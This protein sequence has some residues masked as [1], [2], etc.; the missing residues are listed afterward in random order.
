MV[1][2]T[3]ELQQNI[4][5]EFRSASVLFCYMLI[6]ITKNLLVLIEWPY[7][8]QL[9][10][11]KVGLIC[12]CST[13]K[14]VCDISGMSVNFLILGDAAYP[15]LDWFMKAYKQNYFNM[16]ISKARAVVEIAFGTL[17]AGSSEQKWRPL[18]LFTVCEKRK[19]L[20]KP[21]MKKLPFWREPCLSRAVMQVL[22][23][24]MASDFLHEQ[25][26]NILYLVCTFSLI[27]IL[28]KHFWLNTVSWH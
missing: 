18:H 22:I 9:L 21:G 17:K 19:L 13:F 15:L 24:Y 2:S 1:K 12:F 20:V 4:S 10:H 25:E 5:A 11:N 7:S 16:Y 3:L 26:Q 6:K 8:N 14:H 28:V 23:E 27:S